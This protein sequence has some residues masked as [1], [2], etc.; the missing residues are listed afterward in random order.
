M[1][2]K[3]AN[4][5]LNHFKQVRLHMCTYNHMQVIPCAKI[6]VRFRICLLIATQVT[7]VQQIYLQ[8]DGFRTNLTNLT[9]RGSLSVQ[10][11]FRSLVSTRTY[12]VYILTIL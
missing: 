7:N 5:S 11:H 12:L 2:E 4:C 3:H 1:F 8:S 6:T 10:I 9:P